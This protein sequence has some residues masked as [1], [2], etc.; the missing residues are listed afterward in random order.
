MVERVAENVR[1][2]TGQA[3]PPPGDYD[4]DLVHSEVNFLARHLMVSKVRGRFEDFVGALHIGLGLVD[5]SVRVTIQAASISTREP[6]RD[7]HLRSPD[8]LD[9]EQFPE[10]VFRSKRI[11]PAGGSGWKVAGDLTIRG[12]TREVVLDAEFDGAQ[13]DM[14]GSLRVGCS[15]STQIK[16]EDWG[17]QWNVA[18]ETGGVLV[19][20]E[21][22]I[23]LGVEAVRQ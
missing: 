8:F 18:L 14:T 11:E 4:L 6:Q 22:T 9:A 5:S 13:V 2:V 21:V 10:I 23:E 15:A 3:F 12:V 20:S 7:A 17:L 1:T 16:R 19:G